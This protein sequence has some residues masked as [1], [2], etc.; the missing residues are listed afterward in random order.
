MF[1]T[2]I[3]V[4]SAHTDHSDPAGE[5]VAHYRQ[6]LGH[7]NDLG[8]A[9]AETLQRQALAVAADAAPG[10]P[11]ALAAVQDAAVVFER[12]FRGVRRGIA[13]AQRLAE[14]VAPGRA[15][16]VRNELERV[17]DEINRYDGLGQVPDTLLN[18]SLELEREAADGPDDPWQRPVRTIVAE[19]CRDLGL[20]APLADGTDA[21]AADGSAAMAAAP[22]GADLAV[23]VR[24]IMTDLRRAGP[25][26]GGG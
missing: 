1:V 12:V 10:D 7:L 14:P 26:R 8:A 11:E 16:G 24:G 2:H 3:D 13:L 15:V 19:I 20:A 9:L 17:R 4:F 23:V 5:E 21:A 18:R 6:M 25:A 22:D